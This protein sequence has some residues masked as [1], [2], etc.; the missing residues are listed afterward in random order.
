MAKSTC[1]PATEAAN[2]QTTDKAH[3]TKRDTPPNVRT[4][5]MRACSLLTW[6]MVEVVTTPPGICLHIL[7]LLLCSHY[8][9]VHVNQV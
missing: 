6:T 5:L 4:S 7:L 9:C 8:L 3:L 1:G 2:L